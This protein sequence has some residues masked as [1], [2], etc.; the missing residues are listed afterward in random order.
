MDE[1]SH[2]R[3]N[4]PARGMLHAPSVACGKNDGKFISMT[5]RLRT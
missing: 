5:G 3:P 4:Q 1:V 2:S